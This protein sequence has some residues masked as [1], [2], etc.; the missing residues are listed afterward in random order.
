MVVV[1]T[2]SM[3]FGIE[4]S[5]DIPLVVCSVPMV[6]RAT[7]RSERRQQYS[8]TKDEYPVMVSI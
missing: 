6:V 1:V 8:T 5:A 4:V 7:V 2:L 3:V